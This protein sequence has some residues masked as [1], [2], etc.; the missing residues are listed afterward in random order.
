MIC[1]PGYTIADGIAVKHPGVLPSSIL[2]RRPRRHRRVSDEEIS[3]ALVLCVERTKLLVEGAGAVGLAALLAGRIAGKGSVAVVLSGGNIDATTLISVLRHGLTQAGRFLAIRLLIPDRPGELRERSR[4]VARGRGNVVSVDHHREGR[5]TTRCRPRS[6]SSSR[7]RDEAHCQELC[8]RSARRATRSSAS[9]RLPRLAR[10]RPVHPADSRTPRARSSARSA[11]RRSTPHR[12]RGARSARSSASSSSTSSGRPRARS[13]A[14]P[15]TC[16]RCCARTTNARACELENFGGTVEKFI[17]DAVVAVFGAPVAHEDDPER[18]VRAALAVRDAVARLNEEEPGRDL[19]VR[20]AVNTGEA[21]VSLDAAPDEG[22]AMVAGDV[23]QHRRAH[24]VGRAGRRH[25]RR[26]ADLPSDRARRSSTASRARRGEGQGGAGAACGRPSR[27]DRGSASTSAER[28]AHPLVGRDRELDLLV[29]ALQ[30]ARGDRS[31]QL[32]TLVGVPGIGK[33][34]LLYELG[35]VVDADEELITWRQGRSL[36][37]GEGASF[38][39]LGEIVKAQAGILESDSGRGHRGEA[40]R[41]PS[42]RRR[43]RASALGRA[44][45]APARRP[46]RRRSDRRRSPRRGVRRLAPLPRGARARAG[47]PCSS[48]RTSTGPTT[49][50]S[51]SSTA[52]ST[53]STACRSSS[54]A[55]RGRSCSSAAPAGVEGSGTRP[56]SRSRRSTTTRPRASSSRCSSAP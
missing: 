36:P 27:R 40:R 9:G 15:R 5:T 20:V 47:R 52:S 39:A 28:D 23:D 1:Q 2:D 51:T 25:P 4:P 17:G 42:R 35:R 33:S 22:E 10:W 29:D 8:R 6:S 53:G 43:T 3:E 56:P 14:I 49:A 50:C 48:S 7:T 12:L 31:T 37:Y 19:H 44:T 26:R 16:A 18:A 38:W 54:S 32:V 21:L 45:P 41:T 46:R 13:R 11:A 24:P 34:R 55:R 30:R